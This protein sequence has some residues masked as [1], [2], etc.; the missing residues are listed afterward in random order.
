MHACGEVRSGC[1][2]VTAMGVVPSNLTLS[3]NDQYMKVSSF[4][5]EHVIVDGYLRMI[6]LRTR[7]ISGG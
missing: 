4:D 7:E 6:V 5:V 2:S 1:R 3:G